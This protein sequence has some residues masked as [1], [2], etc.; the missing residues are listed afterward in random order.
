MMRSLGR[1]LGVVTMGLVASMM[2]GCLSQGEYDRLVETNR[3][4]Q[5][6]NADLQRERDE[7]RLALNQLRG[8][9]TGREATLADLQARNAELQR[10]L[11]EALG[12]FRDLEG[13]MAG[14]QFG[15]LD[16]ETDAALKE[17]AAQFPNLIRYDEARGMLRFASD[18]TFD[19]GSAVVRPDATEALKALAEVLNNSAALRYEVV[20]EGHTDSQRLSAATAQRHRDN[21]TLSAHRAIS[22]IDVLGQMGVASSRMMAA[23]WGEHRPAVP[24]TPSGNTPQN[25]RVEIYLVRAR[26]GMDAGASAEPAAT[27]GRAAPDRAAPPQR[28]PDIVK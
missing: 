20:I 11:D 10:Q 25:R 22:V 28:Q 17:L 7:A 9:L 16:A 4:L 24:N 5:A 18:L 15:P 21:R 2:G 13:R 27:G 19:S 14:L 1:V 26:G 12:N 3:S 8:G 6:L 23:G